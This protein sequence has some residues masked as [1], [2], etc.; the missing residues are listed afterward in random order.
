MVHTKLFNQQY[1]AF[2]VY[3]KTELIE[4]PEDKHLVAFICWRVKRG[5]SNERGYGGLTENGSK[6]GTVLEL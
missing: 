2:K 5:S 3:L 4:N 6:Y 1:L